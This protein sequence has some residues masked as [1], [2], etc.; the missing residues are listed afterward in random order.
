MI[1][2][3]KLYRQKF[4]WSVIPVENKRPIIEWKQYQERLPDIIEIEAWWRDRPN[5]NIAVVTGRISGLVVFDCDN[6]QAVDYVK[7]RGILKTAS[8]QSSSPTKR[9]YYFKYPMEYEGKITCMNARTRYRED[10]DVKADG[11]YIIVPPS[12]HHSGIK[13]QWLQ[14]PNKIAEL[15]HWQLDFILNE[16]RYKNKII[17]FIPRWVQENLENGTVKGNRNNAVYALARY[18][19]DKQFSFDKTLDTLLRWNV[20]KNRPPLRQREVKQAVRSAFRYE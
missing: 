4:N 13:Y 12:V 11:G 7:A 2:F 9:H 5:A 6:Q 17:P 8:V 10:I 15:D 20:E 18:H 14:L 16:Y 19:K 1:K 3:A